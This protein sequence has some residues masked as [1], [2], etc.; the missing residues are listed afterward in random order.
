L[1]KGDLNK[2]QHIHNE[3]V[4]TFLKA[5]LRNKHVKAFLKAINKEL[6]EDYLSYLENNIGDD[7]SFTMKKLKAIKSGKLKLE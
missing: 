7:A 5:N 2:M 6:G 1:I 3:S 4:L